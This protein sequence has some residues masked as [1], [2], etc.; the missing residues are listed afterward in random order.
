MRGVLQ[1]HYQIQRRASLERLIV[2]V[3]VIVLT[4]VLAANAWIH[5]LHVQELYQT[6][7]TEH[8]GDGHKSKYLL[9]RKKIPQQPLRSEIQRYYDSDPTVISK[10]Y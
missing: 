2:L 1:L 7:I 3:G 5:H 8:V 6:T 9:R 10:Q 4:F